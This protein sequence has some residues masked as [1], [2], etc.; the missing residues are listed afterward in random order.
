[1][2]HD[3]LRLHPRRLGQTLDDLTEIGNRY[4][5]TPGEAQARDYLLERFGQLGLTNVR[6]EAFP[7][8]GASRARATCSVVG[9]GTE[10]ECHCLQ[11]TTPGPVSGEAIYLGEAGEADFRRLERGGTKLRG[12][13]VLAAR[14]L[15]RKANL[16][17]A[18]QFVARAIAHERAPACAAAHD[19][20]DLAPARHRTIARATS[21]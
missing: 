4:S 21:R 9:A 13:V 3:V 17:R 11:Y 8:L 20:F 2:H 19:C 12:S 18:E 14:V 10:I 16:G 5:G 15:R 1:M 6:L 7:Y